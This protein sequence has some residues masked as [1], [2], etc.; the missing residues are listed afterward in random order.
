MAQRYC[1][2]FSLV[3]LAS[4][5]RKEV[6]VELSFGAYLGGGPITE[7]QSKTY[8][9]WL[10]ANTSRLRPSYDETYDWE[11]VKSFVSRAQAAA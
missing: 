2:E 11:R 10:D 8:C 5:Y 3:P 4:A 9:I 6:G 7:Q 1:D